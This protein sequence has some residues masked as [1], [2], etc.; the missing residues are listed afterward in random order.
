MAEP[1]RV[2]DRQR[3]HTRRF[4]PRLGRREGSREVCRSQKG[5]VSR[6]GNPGADVSKVSAREGLKRPWSPN[7]TTK[8]SIVETGLWCLGRLQT[9][10]DRERVLR[11]GELAEAAE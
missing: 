8:D 3:G 5:K 1:V 2:R 10:A 6:V 9:D 11:Q 4:P 7:V